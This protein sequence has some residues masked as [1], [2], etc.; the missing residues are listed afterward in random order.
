MTLIDRRFRLEDDATGLGLYCAGDGVF[1]GG[2]ALLRKAEIGWV[3][4]PAGE[5]RALLKAAYG[6]EVD[7]TRV[8]AGLEA[9][10]NALNE[11]DLSRAMIASVLLRLPNVRGECVQ[12]LR[13]IDEVLAKYDPQEARD[14]HGRW[15]TGGSEATPVRPTTGRPAVR[16]KPLR[17]R[18]RT[19]PPHRLATTQVPAINTDPHGLL[20]LQRTLEGKFDV[21]DPV[22]FS[23]RVYKF[24]DWL[25]SQ[26]DKLSAEERL[27]AKA[28]YAFLQDRLSFWIGYKYTPALA[29]GNL[30]SAAVQL[31]A[32]ANHAGLVHPGG[33]GQGLPASFL[34]AGAATMAFD[35]GGSVGRVRGPRP[36]FEAY[37]SE[38]PE[39][40]GA[41][42]L[43]A[44]MN[45]RDV[46]V[47][48][49]PNIK[50]QGTPMEDAY[51]REYPDA[52]RTEDNTKAFDFFWET[53]GKAVSVKTLNTVNISYIKKPAQIYSRIARYVDDVATYDKP[54]TGYDLNPKLITDREIQLGIPEATSPEQL[55]YVIRAWNYARSKGVNLEITRLR[56]GG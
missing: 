48:W 42:R 43:G 26:G 50:A 55:Q 22:E 38:P 54:R 24:G 44:L 1:L 5:I 3:A 31:Y 4:R 25:Y 7:P 41:G 14:S 11:G 34:A 9:A 17:S 56:D 51:A 6:G 47:I 12:M 28:E 10:A 8:R 30:L 45:N 20:A 32:A 49:G 27:R 13:Q 53:T 35:G 33:D 18:A 2:T 19:T 29:H 40:V 36:E 52:L 15:T 23:K 21:L 37:R 16:R 39:L 46:R